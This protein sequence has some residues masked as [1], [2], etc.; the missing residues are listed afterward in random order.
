[1]PGKLRYRSSAKE[2]LD[3]SGISDELVHK[4]LKE[5]D[6][7]N[8][9]FGGVQTSLRG[10]SHLVTDRNKIYHV[11][12]I[13]C[14]SGFMMRKMAD[15]AKEHNF[16]LVFTGIDKNPVI[17]EYLNASSIEYP[18]IR[19]LAI[20]YR[21]FHKVS[22]YTDIVHCSLFCHHL[23]DTALVNL[24]KRIRTYSTTGLVINDLQRN[25]AAYLGAWL[26]PR[27]L[28]G[29]VLSKHDG[30][31]SVLRAFRKKEL[32]DILHRAGISNY[33]ISR[34]WAFRYLVTGKWKS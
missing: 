23:Q 3:G 14:G 2:M 21:N 19:G 5:M 4:N 30:P 7:L 34:R 9:Y 12:D 24:L 11:T 29:T 20:D 16:R 32:R 13:G 17:I 26:F 15:W 27:I 22:E 31:V 33:Q 1:M 25:Y 28:R 10:L 8:Q 18:E 6:F